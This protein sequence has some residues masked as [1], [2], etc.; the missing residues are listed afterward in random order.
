[1][2]VIA[3]KDLDS[4]EDLARKVKAGEEHLP[5]ADTVEVEDHED[6]V[7]GVA[8]EEK[9]GLFLRN[10]ESPR[11]RREEVEFLEV[12]DV[13]DLV[14]IAVQLDALV[15]LRGSEKDL[16]RETDHGLDQSR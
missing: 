11:W 16:L 2:D 12:L 14:V 6:R 3:V 15:A 10:D 7:V 4:R 8:D 5:G 1:M 9:I 13:V